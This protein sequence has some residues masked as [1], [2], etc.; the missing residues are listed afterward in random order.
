MNIQANKSFSK[1]HFELFGIDVDFDVAKNDLTEIKKKLLLE[2]HP[3]KFSTGTS[4]QK[5]LALQ[6]TSKINEAFEILSDPVLRASYICELSGYPINMDNSRSLPIE[7]IEA[8]MELREKLSFSVSS[9]ETKGFNS[10]EIE[11]LEEEANFILDNSVAVLSR[12][13]K[14]KSSFDND[15]IS[16]IKNEIHSCLFAKKFL[17][18]C[19]SVRR[20]YF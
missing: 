15:L 16:K 11:K 10:N 12:L 3:D 5:R 1:N 2:S 7:L 8:Q 20:R 17:S 19:S 9:F 13:L 4:T 18:E 14:K 6:W